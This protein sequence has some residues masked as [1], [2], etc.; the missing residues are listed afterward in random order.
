[1][2]LYLL[3][4][5]IMKFAFSNKNDSIE[6]KPIQM[7]SY[8]YTPPKQPLEWDKPAPIDPQKVDPWAHVHESVPPKPVVPPPDPLDNL[9]HAMMMVESGGA[10]NVIG[11]KNL[12]NKAYGC[13]Q[14]RYGVLADIN[15]LWRTKYTLNN[16]L[17]PSGCVLS[18]KMCKDYF[19]KILPRYLP[20]KRPPTH[21][22]CMRAWNGGPGTMKSPAANPTTEAQLQAYCKR[23]QSF[24]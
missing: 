19:T 22:E 18:K 17:D 21:I 6:P 24:L 8:R 13:M 9:I 12:I 3:F 14:I 11:D 16:L 15:A 2:W 4:K 20:G 10:V 5:E 23:V 7:I 1:M